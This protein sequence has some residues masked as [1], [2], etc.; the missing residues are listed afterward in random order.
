MDD[1]IC[2]H[3]GK[4][5]IVRGIRIGQTADIGSIGLEYKAQFYF[6]NTEPLVADLCPACGVIVRFRVHQTDRKWQI[7]GK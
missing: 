1:E 3:C 2:P 6:L 7:T 5:K 4:G